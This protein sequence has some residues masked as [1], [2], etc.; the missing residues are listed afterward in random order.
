L[1]TEK[2]L[3]KDQ[4]IV[5][6]KVLKWYKDKNDLLLRFG[7]FAG[8][9]KTFL[10]S[11]LAKK[12]GENTAFCCFTGKAANV[13]R[14]KLNEANVQYS[15][16][17]T[18]HGLIYNPIVDKRSLEVIGW[19]RKPDI[20]ENL[21]VI[22]EASMVGSR[23]WGDLTKFGVKILV[24]GD[25]FQLPPINSFINLMDK[26]DITLEKIHRQA[27]DN[28]I[29]RLSMFVREGKDIKNFNVNDERIAYVSRNDYNKIEVFF[30]EMFNN[31]DPLEAAVLSLFN[32]TRNKN[33]KIIREL[34]GRKNQPE[35]D[36][37]VICLRNIHET[38]FSV[39]NGM[40]GVIK[41]SVKI[42]KN[43]YN[44]EINFPYDDLNI[45]SDVSVHQF[46]QPYTFSNILDLK[47][48]GMKIKKWSD[49]GL[50]FD[51]GYALTTHKSQGSQFE[52]VMVFVEK[53]K[54]KDDE[55]FNRWL[56]T[57]ITRSSINLALVL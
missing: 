48:F 1:I 9:G 11:I 26:P 32:N 8:T 2:D 45:I 30:N 57:S 23:I 35:E 7:G 27:E 6:N 46:N 40:R 13:L 25:H 47:N 33:N 20:E 34:C 4:K 28:P 5:Y 37:L 38:D 56:Y 41:N 12:F 52:N 16:C 3:S 50:L 36:E 21:I 39:F 18:I 10:L 54:G 51:Y 24:V 42:N 29:I 55:Y 19:I 53:L 17:G 31:R 14:T 15:Y 43:I 49:V 44:M 22:D